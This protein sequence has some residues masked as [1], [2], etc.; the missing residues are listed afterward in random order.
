MDT[1]LEV[2]STVVEVF[3]LYTATR[4]DK[5]SGSLTAYLRDYIWFWKS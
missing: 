1:A 2:V 4:R 5:R 3:Y